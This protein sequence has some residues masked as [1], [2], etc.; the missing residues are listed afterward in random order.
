M[1][2]KITDLFKSAF[3]LHRNFTTEKKIIRLLELGKLLV[4]NKFKHNAFFL[5]L[6]VVGWSHSKFPFVN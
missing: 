1:K 4:G 5:K 3:T 2:I 6:T